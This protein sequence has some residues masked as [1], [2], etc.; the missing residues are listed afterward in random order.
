[1]KKLVSMTDMVL[2]SKLKKDVDFGTLKELTFY[3]VSIDSYAEF[4]RTPLDISMFVPCDDN[5]IPLEGEIDPDEWDNVLFD[6]FSVKTHYEGAKHISWGPL[7]VY[8]WQ[9][10]TQIWRLSMNIKIIEHLTRFGL[11][12]LQDKILSDES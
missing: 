1:M 7:S 2:Q 11:T 3:Y 8:W 5:N 12:I 10:D 6:G 9:P 4:L